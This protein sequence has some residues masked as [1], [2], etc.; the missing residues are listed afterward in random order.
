MTNN[1]R[2]RNIVLGNLTSCVPKDLAVY[3]YFTDKT[4]VLAETPCKRCLKVF[5]FFNWRFICFVI[6]ST[7]GVIGYLIPFNLIYSMM[8]SKGQTKAYSSLTLSLSGA[9]SITSRVLIGF[10][11]DYRCLHRIYYF[12]FAMTLCAMI[13]VACLHLTVYWQ[14]FVYGFLYGV[15]TGKFALTLTMQNSFIIK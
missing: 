2:Q 6:A 11:G 3:I 1:L 5:N 7:F 14:F 13:N 12:I 4:E 8:T 10:A 15:G 9:G